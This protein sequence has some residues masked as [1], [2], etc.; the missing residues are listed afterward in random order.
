MLADQPDDVEH[1]GQR[2]IIAVIDEAEALRHALQPDRAGMGVHRDARLGVEPGLRQA[3]REEADARLPDLRGGSGEALAVGE[4]RLAIEQLQ[5]AGLW[6]E[7]LPGGK[8]DQPLVRIALAEQDALDLVRHGAH[9]VLVQRAPAELAA[10]GPAAA[11]AFLVPALEMLSRH[12]MAF[13]Q[14]RQAARHQDI[15]DLARE[16]GAHG[17]DRLGRIEPELRLVLHRDIVARGQALPRHLLGLARGPAAHGIAAH[18]R[19]G[20]AR[21][22]FDLH[23]RLLVR[24]SR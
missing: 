2:R 17:E 13:E 23:D 6:I 11:P 3:E 18:D 10:I 1:V 12:A 8:F 14:Q 7:P 16:A 21:I 5:T 9:R 20:R 24:G 15:L 19:E 22:V 4:R